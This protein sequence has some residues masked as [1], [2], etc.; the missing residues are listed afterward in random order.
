MSTAVPPVAA[1]GGPLRNAAAETTGAAS[2]TAAAD[3][4]ARVAH[5]LQ[6][7]LAMFRY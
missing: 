4:F 1:S 6:Q 7:R 3:E 5:G 2:N